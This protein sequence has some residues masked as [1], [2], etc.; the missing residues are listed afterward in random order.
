M[1]KN[2]S[3][4][5][6][7]VGFVGFLPDL[8][9]SAGMGGKTGTA[10]RMRQEKT[11]PA[12]PEVQVVHCRLNRL[13]DI[14]FPGKITKV[15]T[16]DHRQGDFKLV[17]TMVGA[18]EHLIVEPLKAGASSDFFIYG[19]DRVSYL[20]VRTVPDVREY[21]LRFDVEGNGAEKR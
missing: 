15:V 6:A 9:L 18:E 1:K 10:V 17:W 7:L 19:P 8:A 14:V 3:I 21:D 5:L 16:S 11:V 13:T 12:D 20:K 2:L 4:M